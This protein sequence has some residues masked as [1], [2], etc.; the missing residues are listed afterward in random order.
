MLLSQQLETP[1]LE[2]KCTSAAAT[3]AATAATAAATATAATA[4]A[5]AAEDTVRR[6][7]L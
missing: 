6:C 1:T 5:A 4:G 2:R 7:Q 3:A